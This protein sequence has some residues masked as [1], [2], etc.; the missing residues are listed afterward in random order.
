LVRTKADFQKNNNTVVYSNFNKTLE[1]VL[2]MTKV[3]SIIN[4]AADIEEAK[5]MIK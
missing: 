5:K 2:K 3:W 4:T 1:D